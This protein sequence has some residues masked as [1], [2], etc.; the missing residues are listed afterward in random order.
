M[1]ASTCPR[2]VQYVGSSDREKVFQQL[3]VKN[4]RKSHCLPDGHFISGRL[5]YA[6]CTKQIGLR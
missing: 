3:R 5:W 2:Y 1:S 4:Q 6:L